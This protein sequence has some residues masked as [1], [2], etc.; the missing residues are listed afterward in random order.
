MKINKLFLSAIAIAISQSFVSVYATEQKQLNEFSC[1]PVNVAK[2]MRPNNNEFEGQKYQI[3][4][5]TGAIKSRP[6]V[7][8]TPGMKSGGKFETQKHQISRKGAIED[9]VTFD[10]VRV[11]ELEP[12]E[13][14]IECQYKTKDGYFWMLETQA[15][16]KLKLGDRVKKDVE[17]KDVETEKGMERY[18]SPH[19]FYSAEDPSEIRFE[20]I[21]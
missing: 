10:S 1:P 16:A 7:K 19:V 2:T 9:I 15:Q 11:T 18:R 12:D 13:L 20:R 6:P 14:G 4:S 21:R 3:S 8:V 17:T 5:S